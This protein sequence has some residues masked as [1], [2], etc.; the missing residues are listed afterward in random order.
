MTPG[1]YPSMRMPEYLRLPALSAS[2]IRTLIDECPKA[3]HWKSYLNPVARVEK[4]SKESDIGIAS[5]AI[6]LENN[7]ALM[8]EVN[9]LDFIGPKGGVP[10]GWTTDA[11]KDAAANIRASG[12]IPMLTK[13]VADVR[14]AVAS[15]RE[16]I[17]SLRETEPA[18]WAMFQPD[19]GDSELTCVWDEDGTLCK[20]RP[21]RIAKDRRITADLKFTKRSAEPESQGR[22]ALPDGKISAG[23]YNRGANR[24]FGVDM[25][26]VFIVTE[27]EPPYLTSCLGVDPAS[28]AIGAEKCEFGLREW[29]RCVA[30]NDFPGYPNRVCYPETP[31][32]ER[33]QWEER[34]VLSMEERMELGSQA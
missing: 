33:A 9:P 2:I 16:F 24:V 6:V 1:A 22:L 10:V 32:W 5:H 34:Q 20:M 11:I 19:G 25:A 31:T 21:D 26:Y 4:K 7:D 27:M 8:V 18:I 13:D 12:R 15:A 29:Q 14:G 30:A 3:A 17:E 28:M 23:W